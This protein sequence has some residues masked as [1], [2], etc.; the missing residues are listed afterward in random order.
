M[1]SPVG[2]TAVGLL[3]ARRLGVTSKL[4]LAGAAVLASVPDTDIILSLVL[5]RDLWKLH[6]QGM[7]SANFAITAGMLLGMAGLVRASDSDGERDVLMDGM[8]GAAIMSSHVA[9]DAL[10]IPAIRIGPKFLN[11]HVGHWIID[12]LAWTVLA[13]LLWPRDRVRP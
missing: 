3:V 7:H 13:W 2:H 8:T 12:S 10:P 11:M 6:R 5:H 4:G 1:P 9:I